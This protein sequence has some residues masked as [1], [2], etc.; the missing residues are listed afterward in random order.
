DEEMQN[1]IEAVVHQTQT[2][3]NGSVVK[4]RLASD[5]F[6]QGT[7][8]PRNTFLYGIAAVKGERLEVK[9]ANIQYSNSIFPVDLAV[10]DIDGICGIYIPG[11]ISRDVAKA[12]ADQSIQTLG[13]TGISDSWGAQAAGMGLEAAKS[14]M[15]KKAK[16]VKAVV[17][18]GYRVLLY[19]E[20]QKNLKP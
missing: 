15:G 17:K 18:A 14:L 13:L 20:K 11:A 10:Y 5:I 12:S 16:L 9:I 1:S 4:L 6:L 8:I 7:T 3:I 2:I 19:D